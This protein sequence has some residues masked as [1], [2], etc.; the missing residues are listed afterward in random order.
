[1]SRNEKTKVFG[2]GFHRTGT[3]SLALALKLLGYR[4]TGEN[5]INNPEI[6]KKA[7]EIASEYVEDFDAFQDNPWPLLYREMD[8]DY[9]GSKFILTIRDE[10]SWIQSVLKNFGG[11]D[12][13]ARRWIYGAGDPAGNEDVYLARY[14]RH[15]AE[16]QEY[17]KNRPQDFLVMRITEG[18]GWEKLCPF[19]GHPIP[20]EPFPILNTLEDKIRD[21]RLWNRLLRRLKIVDPEFTIY[22]RAPDAEQRKVLKPGSKIMVLTVGAGGGPT[23]AAEAVQ[24][25]LERALPKADIHLVDILALPG[26]RPLARMIDDQYRRI[27]AEPQ[28]WSIPYDHANRSGNSIRVS[29]WMRAWLLKD[30]LVNGWK[31]R[32]A[33]QAIRKLYREEAW[34]FMIST[35]AFTSHS[36]SRIQKDAGES[37]PLFA[38]VTTDFMVHFLDIYPQAD[39]IYAASEDS[40]ALMAALGIPQARLAITGIPITMDFQSLPEREAAQDR[41]GLTAGV[42]VILLLSGGYGMDSTRKA[43]RQLLRVPQALQVV[44][45]AGRN[46]ALK[47]DLERITPPKRHSV[48]VLAYTDQLPLWLRAADLVLSKPGGLTC[49]EIFACGAPLGIINPLPGPEQ[50]NTRYLLE[51]GA[52]VSIEH[53]ELLP[54]KVERLLAQ[55]QA[56]E[57]LRRNA[58]GLARPTAAQEVAKDIRDRFFQPEGVS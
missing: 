49:A 1:M 40:A 16:V 42:P 2:I 32:L 24:A 9:P 3:T 47:A 4:V 48:R 52:A 50:F 33:Y 17:F 38:I 7:Y 18:D 35:A 19:L 29:P 51:H 14:R 46:A 31:R 22:H 53:L 43:F 45:A 10:D 54:F 26:G 27:E 25:A 21:M 44:V 11:K 37:F 57:R 20:D 13:P 6:G 23:R 58:A 39:R 28:I 8:A 15:N 55:P 36:L 34:D 30:R 41:L 12:T 5:G 56:L